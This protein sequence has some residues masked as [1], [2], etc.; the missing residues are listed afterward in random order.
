MN[1]EM[2]GKL[3]EAKSVEDVVAIAREYGK[4][5]AVEQAQALLDRVKAAVTGELS[6]DALGAVAGG[7][8]IGH[9]HNDPLRNPRVE[10]GGQGGQTV[11]DAADPHNW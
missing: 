5:L 9:S 8:T 6:D 4:E 2:I 3:K 7:R 11:E 10:M 1:E